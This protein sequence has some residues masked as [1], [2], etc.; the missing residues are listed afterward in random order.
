MFPSFVTV[1]LWSFCVVCAN[2]AVRLVGSAAANLSRLALATVLLALWA[3]LFGKGLQGVGLLYFV[4]SGVV[5]FGF[6]DIAG[7]E[8]L[9]RIGSRLTILLAQCL[10]AP[11]AALVEWLWLGTALSGAQMACGAAI[12]AGVAIAV[13]PSDQFEIDREHL[14]AGVGFGVLACFGQGGG[15]VLSRKAYQ[16]VE[17]AGQ[18]ID[19]GTAAFQ[20]IIGGLGLVFVFFVLVELRGR[21]S[22]NN[23]ESNNKR[24]WER[25]WPWIVAH[26][27]TGPVIGVSC[28][29]W[30]L[31]TTP[32]GVVLPII[33][34]TPLAVIPFAYF[35]EHD[36]PRRR[37]LVGGV[38]AV[39]GGVALTL[40]K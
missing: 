37:S 16:L 29:Q 20:R 10:A 9:P 1:V 26:T 40:V 17:S 5:G 18:T 27:L 7:Y 8:A 36:R 25:A 23:V 30:A 35:I 11:F 2:R 32:S 22:A 14:W 15:A 3:Y 34:T 33:A 38:I 39:A 31:A 12:L 19:G 24:P 6:G 4:L 28:Y 13:A 21:R